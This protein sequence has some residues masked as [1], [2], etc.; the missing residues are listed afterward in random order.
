[1]STHAPVLK[2]TA[3]GRAFAAPPVSVDALRAAGEDHFADHVPRELNAWK[4]PLRSYMEESRTQVGAWIAHANWLY[5]LSGED[6][7]PVPEVSFGLK[8]KTGGMVRHT[9]I[10]SRIVVRDIRL[11]ADLLERFPRRMIA[12]VVPH[13]VA[14]A[15]TRHL[16]GERYVRPHGPEWKA[17]MSDF[18]QAPRR[19][20]SMRAYSA[21][22]QR[23]WRPMW[24]AGCACEPHFLVHEARAQRLLAGEPI[25]CFLC[26]SGVA[27][28]ASEPTW[29]C[30]V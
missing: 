10:R 21:S 22:D 19:C 3:V 28:L 20:H 23:H 7:I 12:E 14:H 1:M 15:V 4:R 26:E 18:G 30:F 29:R 24:W 5:G 2:R 8:G 13:E 17:V 25:Q 6:Q 16:G 11:N 9:A 27:L